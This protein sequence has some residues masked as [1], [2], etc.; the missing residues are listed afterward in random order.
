M[1][2][3]VTLDNRLHFDAH[4]PDICCKVG[5][6]VTSLN[7]LKIIYL[8]KLSKEELHRAYILPTSVYCSQV[9]HHCG[10]R[11]TSKLEKVN[12]RALR[13]AIIQ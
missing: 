3:G 4:I 11:N 1:L 13:H 2:L 10:D 6:Q 12:E 5:E 8:V 7:R 9:W